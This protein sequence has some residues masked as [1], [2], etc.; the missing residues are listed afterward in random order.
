MFVALLMT[1]YAGIVPLADS[2]TQS[3][4][5]Y[6]SPTG[7]GQT[8]VTA[9][10]QASTTDLTHP[11]GPTRGMLTDLTH[12]VSPGATANDLTHPNTPGCDQKDDLTHP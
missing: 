4:D 11:F 8:V 9:D 2:T 1:L 12:P 7:S 3:T 10:W 6:S 5:I